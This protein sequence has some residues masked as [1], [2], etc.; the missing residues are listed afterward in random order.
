MKVCVHNGEEGVTLMVSDHQSYLILSM[1]ICLKR[2]KKQ[3]KGYTSVI[4]S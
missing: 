4:G 1:D 3:Y 2:A